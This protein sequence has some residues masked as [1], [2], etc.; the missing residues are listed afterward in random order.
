MTWAGQTSSLG[1]Y[2]APWMCITLLGCA[3]RSL[4]VYCALPLFGSSHPSLVNAQA[5]NTA[6]VIYMCVY[7]CDM[8]A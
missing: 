2:Y 8:Y 7:V 1:V 6:C 3:L 4:G 5:R